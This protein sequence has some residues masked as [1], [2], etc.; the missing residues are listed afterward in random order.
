MPF[1]GKEQAV[2]FPLALLVVDWFT[3]RNLKSSVVW[4]EKMSFFILAFLFGAITI[5]SQGKSIYEIT[6]PL[7]QRLTFAC[8]ALI[9][10]IT[11]SLFPVKLN[12]FYPFPIVLGEELP[13][14]FYIY[15][16]FDTFANRLDFG[17]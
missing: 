14:K 7:Y 2:T 13:L 12:F 5:L 15:P 1:W 8:F 3:N 17:I 4:S 16:V 10:Y 9:E 11:K 6:Y